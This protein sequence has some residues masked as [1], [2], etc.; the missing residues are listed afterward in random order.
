MSDAVSNILISGPRVVKL[1]CAPA[2]RPTEDKKENNN[3]F[4]LQTQAMPDNVRLPGIVDVR[5]KFG[6]S[7]EPYGIRAVDG[8]NVFY[9]QGRYRFSRPI[10]SDR[11]SNYAVLC[12]D[13]LTGKRQRISLRAPRLDEALRN[14]ADLRALL[15][16][17]SA[18][19]GIGP[20]ISEVL[21]GWVE[22]L[23]GRVR[24]S[25][26]E[27]AESWSRR[28]QRNFPCYLGQVTAEFLAQYFEARRRE[29]A[30]TTL[31]TELHMLRWFWGWACEHGDTGTD[32]TKKLKSFPVPERRRQLLTTAEWL[33]VLAVLE[34]DVEFSV[35]VRMA[36]WT[37]LR[38]RALLG[39]RWSFV[40]LG[41]DTVWLRLPPELLKSGRE[42]SIPLF[43]EAANAL[44]ALRENFPPQD[45]TE[46]LFHYN[47]KN[48][49]R[50]WHF[51]CRRAGVPEIKFHALRAMFVTECR[52]RGIQ[53]EVAMRLSDHSDVKTFV[54]VYRQVGEDDLEL[55]VRGGV[56][57]GESAGREIGGGEVGGSGI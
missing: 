31:N 35:L 32:P 43:P 4:R 1:L 28:W 13:R 39:L 30:L 53:L 29:Y 41:S 16:S 52:R 48:L 3:G 24:E 21:E 44:R 20:L 7:R 49:S 26:L 6:V 11:R 38:V 15:E 57:S 55:A 34:A 40:A 33:R 2:E 45:G 25:T 37:G 46:R 10:R 47:A 27:S 51:A 8:I 5:E 12:W 36:R 14:L 54:K 23:R 18:T 50:K 56:P 42:L 9:R 19:Y 17:G 22:S